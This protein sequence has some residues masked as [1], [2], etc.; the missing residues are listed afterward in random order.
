VKAHL[1]RGA[2]LS[3]SSHPSRP[4]AGGASKAVENAA[5]RR[6]SERFPF[7]AVAE[8]LDADSQTKIAAR[9]SDISRHGCY[10][11]VINVFAT[12]TCVELSIRHAN[13]QLETVATVVYSLPGMGMGLSFKPL[14]PA[15]ESILNRWVSGVEEECMTEVESQP[16]IPQ[17][18]EY[19][20]AERHILGRLIGLMIRKNMLSREEGTELLDELLREE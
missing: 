1:S 3:P 8:V 5:D 11:D 14:S 4:E 17:T 15:M 20:R 12:G 7:S 16:V 19:R 2:E 6:R 9:V 10:L 13:L 18:L